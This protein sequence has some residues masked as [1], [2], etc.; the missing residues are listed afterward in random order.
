MW[1]LERLKQIF[2][3]LGK[4]LYLFFDRTMF[5]QVFCQCTPV[6]APLARVLCSIRPSVAQKALRTQ[7]ASPS[8]RAGIV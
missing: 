5:C 7:C 4:F 3:Q 6:L 1:S 2:H 8:E